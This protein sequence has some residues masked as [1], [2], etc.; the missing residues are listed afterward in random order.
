MGVTV[1]FGT[2]AKRRNST[3]QPTNELSD[4]KTVTLKDLTSYDA[5]VFILT[6]D[7]FNYNYAKWGNRYYFITDVK[8]VHNGLCEVTCA[9]DPL[10]T[11]KTEILAST[12]FVSYSSQLGNAWLA[13]TRIPVLKSTVVSKAVSSPSFFSSAG[14]YILSVVG[15]TGCVSYAL[16]G[17]ASL[18]N[19]ISDLQTWSDQFQRDIENFLLNANPQ[20][21]ED[22]IIDLGR[23]LNDIGFLGNSYENAVNAIRSCKWVPYDRSWLSQSSS[24]IYLGNYDT[25]IDGYYLLGDNKTDSAS[26]SIPWHFSDWRRGYCEDVYLYLPLVGM[27]QLSSDSLTHASS[28]TVN[29][30]VSRCAGDI[31]YEVICGNEI[32]GTYGASPSAE[33]PVGINQKASAGAIAQTA[34]AGTQK[35]I[36]SGIHSI[37]NFFSGNIA[38]GIS[39]AVM[40]EMNAIDAIY[41]TENVRASTNMSCIGGIGASA[42]AGLDMSIVCYT[43]AHDTICEPN[44]MKATMGVPTMKTMSLSTLTGFC[45][46][47]NAHIE[48]AAQANELNAIDAMLNSGFFIE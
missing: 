4:V 38:G 26:V 48:C 16:S 17:I 21:E 36:A 6:G 15:K 44:D 25:N 11:Y 9:L 19:L 28:I 31:A 46:C 3:K 43:V 7:D 23:A 39:N 24:R 8:S 32:I 5:P 13:D 29:I 34:F 42:G 12:Q 37:G 18:I 27:V 33:I 10:A 2:F 1:S 30:S 35:T 14:T 40:T 20:S 47:S 41:Q 45:Q 22:S